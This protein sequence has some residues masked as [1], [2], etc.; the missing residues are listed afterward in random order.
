MTQAPHGRD[1]RIAII[2]AGFSGIAAATSLLR[3]GFEDIHIFEAASGLGGTWWHNRYPGAEVDLESHI[4]SFSFEQ[5]DW[6][7]THARWHEILDYLNHVAKKWDLERRILLNERVE[8][9]VWDDTDSVYALT[10]SS[11]I[12]HGKF[13]V[14]ISCVGFLNI[15]IVPAFAKGEHPFRGPT[16]H[17]SRWPEGLTL[18]GKRVGVLGTGSSGVQIVSAAERDATSVTI[19]QL[20]PNWIVPKQAR[21]FTEEERERYRDPA[22]YFAERQR[23]YD[24]YDEMQRDSSHARRDGKWNQERHRK[25]QDFMNT[26]LGDRPDLVE[27]VTPEFAFEARRT[28]NSD[29]YYRAIRNP[30]VRIVPFGAKNFTEKGIVDANGE[31]HELDVVVFATGFDAANYLGGMTVRGREGRDLHRFWD[32][33]PSAFLGMMVPGFPNFFMLYGPNTNSIPLVT[34][35]EAQADFVASVVSDLRDGGA[36]SVEVSPEEFNKFNAW[37][38]S[39]LDR[40]VWGEVRNYFQSG[41]GKIVSQWPEGPSTYLD[42]V[43]RAKQNALVF[44]GQ[45]QIVGASQG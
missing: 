42:L 38:Q 33:E 34:F 8:S 27:L 4:Y 23:L 36:A 41:T 15:P 21:D 19:F 14:V 12:E 35:Y 17:T 43:S 3:S 7:R 9:A 26:E 44:E 29:D 6:S 25:A 20:E 18:G 22:A 31:E 37:V 39:R 32:G 13:D 1:A 24:W 11:G 30:K 10:T 5:Y 28:V 16:C 40:T 45:R 2:G